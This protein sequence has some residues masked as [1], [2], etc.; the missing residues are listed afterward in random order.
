VTGTGND[1][2][3]WISKSG[4]VVVFANRNEPPATALLENC[5]AWVDK[6]LVL[7][8]G[9]YYKS[10]HIGD[11][12]G[13]GKADVISVNQRDGSLNVWLTRYSNG[14]FS[15]SKQTSPQGCCDQGWGVGYTDLGMRFADVTGSGCV[16]AL[17]IEPDGRTTAWLND[18]KGLWSLRDVGQVKV[19]VKLLRDRANIQ[20][21]DVNGKCETDIDDRPLKT[22]QAMDYQITCG[23]CSLDKSEET[24]VKQLPLTLF[25]HTHT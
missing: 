5:A 16:D 12:N 23:E 4:D 10:L 3:V 8:T 24:R 19:A 9:K 25:L 11:W 1:D 20:F 15:F 2:Y 13:D 22:I 14:V 6:G 18:C 7:R 21:S 17:C